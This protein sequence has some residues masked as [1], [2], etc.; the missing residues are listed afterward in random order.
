MKFKYSIL[1][2]LLISIAAVADATSGSGKGP[3]AAAACQAAKDSVLGG[4]AGTKNITKISQCECS[5][6]INAFHQTEY[7][8]TVNA[9]YR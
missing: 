6:S 1:L 8:C 9:Y 2:T 7:D 5:S 4:Y 3:T